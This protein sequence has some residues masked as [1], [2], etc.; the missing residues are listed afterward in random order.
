[1]AG[2][3][4]KEEK[5]GFGNFFNFNLS[6]NCMILIVVLLILILCKEEIMKNKIIKD[7][8]K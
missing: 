3:E 5:E 2:E 7:F 1:M 8:F 4:K 6:Q